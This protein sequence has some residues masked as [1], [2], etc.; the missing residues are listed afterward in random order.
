MGYFNSDLKPGW[1][2]QQMEHDSCLYR[3]DGPLKD[4]KRSITFAYMNV[5]D[6][7]SV[8]TELAVTMVWK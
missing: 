4:E 5:D 2:V 8:T 1:T 6:I 7:E 3:F